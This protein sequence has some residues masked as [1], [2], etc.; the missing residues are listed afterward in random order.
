MYPNRVSLNALRTELSDNFM[1]LELPS[2]SNEAEN[3]TILHPSRSV[4]YQEQQEM[5]D[6]KWSIQCNTIQ[7]KR[8]HEEEKVGIVRA[9]VLCTLP[10]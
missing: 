9:V 3:T 1:V 7:R 4:P 5:K 2:T 8:R 6:Q 10:S